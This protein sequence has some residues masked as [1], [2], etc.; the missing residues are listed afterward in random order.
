MPGYLDAQVAEVASLRR[1]EASIR[2]MSTRASTEVRAAAQLL[3]EFDSHCALL[4]SRLYIELRS[5]EN[6]E[7]S[8]CGAQRRRYERA[9]A[10]QA[11]VHT[12]CAELQSKLA[13]RRRDIETGGAEAASWLRRLAVQI[14]QVGSSSSGSLVVTGDGPVAGAAAGGDDELNRD[15]PSAGNS[16]IAGLALPNNVRRVS[17]RTE[18]VSDSI[19]ELEPA[20]GATREDMVWAAETFR[21]VILPHVARGG[22]REELR[23]LDHDSGKYT[24]MRRLEGA[25]EVYLGDDMP[26][27]LLDE[28]GDVADVIGGR[29]RI[30]AARAAGLGWIPMRVV[31]QT[32]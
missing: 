30:A 22:T 17:V 1:S 10:I 12:V 28:R 4:V 13:L 27:V 8:D 6:R 7:N 18:A 26:K 29:H 9:I 24:G 21:D 23:Q 20:K 3:R 16:V 14:E 25:W 19:F 15:G 2:D 11:K 31:D 5:C 32:G